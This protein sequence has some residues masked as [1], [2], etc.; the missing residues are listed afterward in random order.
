[1]SELGKLHFVPNQQLRGLG[2]SSSASSMNQ[3][4]GPR[5]RR[6]LVWKVGDQFSLLLDLDIGMEIKSTPRPYLNPARLYRPWGSLPKT[7]VGCPVMVT[8]DTSQKHNHFKE[9][10]FFKCFSLGLFS[11][12]S[13][14]GQVKNNLELT[15]FSELVK[16]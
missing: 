9:T 16:I 6:F 13:W 1:M 3:G 12:L 8:G 15:S 14:V 4:G 7:L 2:Q 11:W 5:S 10:L